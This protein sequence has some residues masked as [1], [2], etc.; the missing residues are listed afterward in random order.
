MTAKP[1]PLARLAERAIMES[2][3]AEVIEAAAGSEAI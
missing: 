3:A 1:V 2:E